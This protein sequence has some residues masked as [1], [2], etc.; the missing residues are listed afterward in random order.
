[1]KRIQ[2]ISNTRHSTTGFSCNCPSIALSLTLCV[3]LYELICHNI[4]YSETISIGLPS[5]SKTCLFTTTKQEPSNTYSN[6]S[7]TSDTTVE[8]GQSFVNVVENE[9]RI[10]LH[11]FR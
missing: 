4:I 11:R 8:R 5:V 7:C 1:M 3:R 6:Y 9:A 2:N 10:N